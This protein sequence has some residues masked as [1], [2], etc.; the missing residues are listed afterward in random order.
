MENTHLGI[1]AP[2][3]RSTKSKHQNQQPKFIIKNIDRIEKQARLSR[4][5]FHIGRGRLQVSLIVIGIDIGVP[6]C[7]AHPL[8]LSLDHLHHR[9]PNVGCLVENRV[10]VTGISYRKGEVGKDIAE[11]ENKKHKNNYFHRCR[12]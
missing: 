10:A 1:I 8:K 2:N 3:H 12:C 11:G 5:T 4:T 6:V 7:G 9:C